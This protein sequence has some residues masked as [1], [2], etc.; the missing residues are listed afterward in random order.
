VNRLVRQ[1]R[2]GTILITAIWIIIVL[3]ALVL[4]FAR[5]M[6]VEA[7]AS[8]NR[9]SVEQA[10]AVERA[11]EQYVLAQVDQS[12]G[13][14][15]TVTSAPG[16]ALP[17]GTGYFWLLRPDPVDAQSYDFGIVD[18]SSKL[19]L[20][21]AGNNELMLLPN[22][23]Q[24]V[25]DSIVDWRSQ[26][27]TVTGQG[28]KNDYY[29][30]LPEP[31]Q[32]KDSPLET[33]EELRLVKMTPGNTWENMLF[34]YDANHNGVIDGLE[35][36]N[37]GGTLSMG[38]NASNGSGRGIFPFVTVYS[39]EPNTDVSGGA[40]TNVNQGVA[41][42]PG[43]QPGQ[44]QQVVTNPAGG[45]PQQAVQVP[46]GNAQGGNNNNNQND[47]VYKALKTVLSGQRLDQV[48]AKAKSSGQF[49]NVLDFAQKV[50][51][52]AQEAGSLLDKLT[53]ADP[54]QNKTLMGLVNVNTAPREVLQCLTG[55]EKAD[56]DAL[57]AQRQSADT[58]NMAWVLQ[59]LK[60]PKLA[61]VGGKLTGRSFRYSA[62]IVGVSGDGRAFCRMR[63]VVDCQ[64]TLP[65]IVYRKDLTAL[66]WPLSED[67]RTA[68]RSGQQL[69]T[70]VASNL[71]QGARS[72]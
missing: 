18:E 52:T 44:A 7:I 61:A 13:D 70:P 60:P 10:A 68:L 55:M 40:R 9:L 54:A 67:I 33:V 19:N 58:K 36:Q 42:G 27:N 56:V 28:A 8:G 15:I 35:A 30:S 38:F 37:G 11:G 51:L 20:N 25:A 1:F 17:V 62:D 64:G 53:T 24:D 39:V 65:K 32:C 59:A 63:I 5:G 34:G 29:L 47:P 66:G 26:G 48:F 4:V 45:A 69:P 43:G 57:L 3:V 2:R 21:T 49:A 22:M 41:G 31:Y 71:P 46:A 14:A 16:E 6:R 72:Q 23:S 50:G 12:L